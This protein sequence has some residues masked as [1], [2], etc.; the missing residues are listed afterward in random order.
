MSKNIEIVYESGIV[1]AD[2]ADLTTKMG[3][4]RFIILKPFH[5][6]TAWLSDMYYTDESPQSTLVQFIPEN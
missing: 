4:T 5:L 6:S 1:I 2:T 3:T